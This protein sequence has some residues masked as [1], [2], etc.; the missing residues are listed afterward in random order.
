MFSILDN[1]IWHSGVSN[2]KSIVTRGNDIIIYDREIAWFAGLNEYNEYQLGQLANHF[3]SGE[4]VILFT[5]EKLMV[6]QTWKVSLGRPLSQM[7]FSGNEEFQIDKTLITTLN[8]EFVPG[9]LSLTS[10]TKPG[11]FFNRTIE[12]GN[13]FGILDNNK[14]VSMTGSRLSLGNFEEISAVC[15]HPDFVG[16][17]YASLLLK[18]K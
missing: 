14:I 8:K 9:M 10:L 7:I 1:P 16:K 13:Y 18:I 2:N 5:A 11:P 15:T 17:G 12:F 4:Q 6:P 3:T